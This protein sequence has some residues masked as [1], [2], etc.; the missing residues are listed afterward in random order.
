PISTLLTIVFLLPGTVFPDKRLD[1]GKGLPGSRAVLWRQPSDIRTRNLLLGPGGRALQP[2]GPFRFIKEDNDGSSPKFVVEDRSGVRWKVKLGDEAKPESAATRLLWAVGYFTD[3]DYYLPEFRVAGLPKLSRGQKYVKSG[4]V[5]SG[6]RLEWVNKDLKKIDDWSWFDNPFVGTRE[7]NG[8]RVMMAL[9]NN[10]DLKQ[11]NNAIYEFRERER[12]YVVS[13]L[14]A[15]FGKTGG[16]WTR[17]KG[18]LTD[19]LE[20]GFVH[21]IEPSKVD[22]VM[23]SRPPVVYAVA[24]PYYVTRTKMTRVARDIPRSDARWIGQLLA[25]LSD[26]Q[27]R[28][29]FR[30]A[31]Y[32]ANVAQAYASEV[33]QR[34]R[35]LVRL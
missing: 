15:T 21:D 2:S 12:R 10:W 35:M 9:M 29:A 25:Q 19:Y 31:G 8:L 28:D 33:R 20:S 17:S 3:V 4:N 22:L 1:Q 30:A 13:D 16:G 32:T 14:G 34:I 11:A 5:V 18:A 24:V 23:K 7:F 6:A 27:I 26:R